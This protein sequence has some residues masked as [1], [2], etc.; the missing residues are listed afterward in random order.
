MDNDVY[1]HVNNVVYYAYFDTVVN[2]YLIAHGGLDIARGPVIGVVVEIVLCRYRAPL[3]F[4]EVIEAGP[5]YAA[6]IGTSSVR[7]EIGLF[8]QGHAHAAAD[9]LLRTRVRRPRDAAAGRDP[10]VHP[11]GDRADLAPMSSG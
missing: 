9:G 2:E 5:S 4:P 3:T 7:Y 10:R 1:Q 6:K 11:R 8:R